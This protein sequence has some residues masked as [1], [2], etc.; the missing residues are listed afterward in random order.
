MRRSPSSK[1]WLPLTKTEARA[2]ELP[3]GEAFRP[4]WIDFERGIRVGNIEP[5]ERITQILKFHLEQRHHTPFVTDRW[6]RGVYWQWICWLPRANR[7]AKPVSHDVNF[8]CA[9]LFISADTDRRVFKSGLQVERGYMTGPEADK[10]WGL[11]D[12]FD[13]HRLVKQCRTGSVLDQELNRLVRREG[14]VA[15]VIGEQAT[16]EWAERDFTS[17]TQLLPAIRRCAPGYWAGFQ[18][19]YPMPEKEV[20]ACTG[21]ELVKAIW[22]VFAEVTPVMNCCMQVPLTGNQTCLLPPPRRVPSKI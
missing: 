1:D 15:A 5:H 20:R 9:K 21:L 12:D 7:I 13:W 10:P 19:Y 17:A 18:L 14:F 6:G 16:G 4:E 3:T 22:N 11:R 2:A 8:G